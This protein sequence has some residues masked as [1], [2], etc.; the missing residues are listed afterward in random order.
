MVPPKS[1][2]RGLSLQKP[3]SATRFATAP[4]RARRFALFGPNAERQAFS[5][6]LNTIP[7][8]GTAGDILPMEAPGHP[9]LRF[10]RI[11]NDST[12]QDFAELNCVS[13]DVPVGGSLSLV[14]E[15]TLWHQHAYGFVAYD[16]NKPVW[17][18]FPSCLSTR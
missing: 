9:A 11:L 10:E 6:R 3:A 4:F 12:I 14:N 13:Y 2:S 16:G 1:R 15:R 8:I 5:W 18:R 17:S 7:M